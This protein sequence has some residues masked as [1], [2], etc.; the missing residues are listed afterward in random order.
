MFEDN[1]KSQSPPVRSVVPFADIHGDDEEDTISL[2]EMAEM[3]TRYV[4]SYPWCV[5]LKDGYFGDGVGGVVGIFLFR[6]AIKGFHDDQW[7][8]VFMGDVPSAYMLVDSYT[9]PHAALSRYIEGLEEWIGKAERGQTSPDL[10]PIEV[11]PTAENMAMIQSRIASLRESILPN[12][13]SG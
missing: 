1:E 13:S 11:S 12:I 3:A 7:I 10:I 8:W 4:R 9:N 2:R 5:E 6:V